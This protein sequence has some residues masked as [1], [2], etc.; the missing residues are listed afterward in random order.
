M[1]NP[2]DS[3]RT[4]TLRQGTLI[5]PP[6]DLD[7][8]LS[9]TATVERVIFKNDENGYCVLL[10][11]PDAKDAGRNGIPQRAFSCVGTHLNP[12]EDMRLRLTGHFEQN[13]RFG[14][15]F[16]F[17][18]ASE[19]IPQSVEGLVAYLS[20]NLIKG[21][22][23]DTAK[24]LVE[25]FGQDTMRVLDEEPER[26]L[27]VKGIGRKTLETIKESWTKNRCMSDLMQFLQP[28]GISA[29]Y[30]VRIFREYGGDALRIVKENP[31]RL[32][33]D[34][35]G[36]GFL[37]ADQIA[38]K[39]GFRDDNP[40]RIQGAVLYMLQKA[41]DS[42]HV[43]VP[44]RYLASRTQDWL[45]VP[46]AQVPA[47][48]EALEY[49]KRVVADHEPLEPGEYPD[50]AGDTAV[51][52]SVYHLCETRTAYYLE[53]LAHYP[54]N[55]VFR[56]KETQ[57]GRALAE[58]EHNLAPLQVEAVKTAARS[59]VM[60]ITGGPGTGKTTIIKAI[61]SLFSQVTSRIFL[62]AP[63]GRAAKR[64]SEATGREARTLHRTLEYNPTNNSFQRNE[65]EPLACDLLIVDEASMMDTLIFFHL[66]KAVPTGC[67]LILVG[68][69]H[70]LPSVG[71][72]AVL[73]DIIESGKVPVCRLETIF[74]QG[75]A[76]AIVTTAHSINRGVIPDM[77]Q[78][79]NAD[80]DFYF[81]PHE[82]A[83]TAPPL[84]ADLVCREIPRKFGFNPMR[85]VQLLT[86]MHK[87][88]VGTQAM[89]QLLQQ[90]LNPGGR[91]R[92]SGRKVGGAAGHAFTTLA[93][94]RR[95]DVVF[96]TGDKVMQ[97]R[98]DYEKEV[99]N[100][101]VGYIVGIDQESRVVRVS[102]DDRLVD[103]ATSELDELVLAYA[104][105]IHKSQGS[106]YPA[107]V[108]PVFMQHGIMLQRNLIY[109]AITRGKKLVVVV[110][111]RR[112]LEMAV[113]R[114]DTHRRFTRLRWRLQQYVTGEG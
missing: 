48:V 64:M 40:L 71:P 39:L 98:N 35:S 89:N 112:A 21:L 19:Q 51:Y 104:I 110:G 103:Y 79:W 62:A 20:S 52:L 15:Q 53:R 49:D 54:P 87:Y 102:F 9:F 17:D 42:G 83:E 85:D 90:T 7:A 59:K 82:V 93:E 37:T 43:F 36:I 105:S 76:S 57:V 65:D 96:R 111:E 4:G 60:V 28:H 41:S 113:R 23:R 69:I 45:H 101:D 74:R 68:D 72:G 78:P 88:E 24:R 34:I 107:V 70:Q 11:L 94:V 67:V 8:E 6:V 14:R 91:G 3:G 22:G 5:R 80:T 44:E 13:N 29:A 108:I 10:V 2:S 77:A 47:T 31:Y 33:M 12:R 86:P 114:N 46:A 61:I 99:F 63:T 58:Q 84:L 38:R 18:S 100:G 109:T 27:E 55:V 25:R 56:E 92:S 1:A 95:G 73:S 30:G 106:E 50:H 97:V 75:K 81:L 26:L 66:L 32:A 16:R